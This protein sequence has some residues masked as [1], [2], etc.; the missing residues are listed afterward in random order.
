MRGF[1]LQNLWYSQGV[2]KYGFVK[3]DGAAS[4]IDQPKKTFRGTTY[5]SDG[6]VAVIWFSSEPVSLSDVEAVNWD[7]P[8]QE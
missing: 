1:L 8:P 3:V 6:Y 4:T 5:I 7:I 2:K